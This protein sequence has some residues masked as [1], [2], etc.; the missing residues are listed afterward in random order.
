[1]RVELRQ[2]S[3]D[4]GLELRG[5]GGLEGIMVLMCSR[6]EQLH[7]DVTSCHIS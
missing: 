3:L 5:D 7:Y 1:M 6:V 2:G 4:P